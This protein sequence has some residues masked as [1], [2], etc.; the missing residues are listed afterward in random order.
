MKKLLALLFAFTLVAAACGG[1]DDDEASE[2]DTSA[3]TAAEG[4]ADEGDGEAEEEE[5]G[6]GEEAEAPSGEAGS[7]G[8]LLLLQWQAPSQA[9]AMLSSGTKDLLAASLVNEPLAK[10]DPAG[11]IVPTLAAEI[12]TLDNGGV[13]E[14]FTSVTWTLRD[15]ITWSDGTPFTS[16]DVV[17]TWEYCADELTGCSADFTTVDTIVADDE[18][19]V[20]VNFTDPQ[21]YPYVDLVGYLEPV[22]QRAQFEE[23]IG[24]QASA[25]TDQNF[26]PIGTGPYMVTELRPEDTVTYEFNPNY[27]GVA[28]GKPFFGSVTI[29]GGGDAE[30][31]ARSVLEIGEA[32]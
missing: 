17:F 3:D 19:T 32:D 18:F 9:N 22:L 24:E 15:D 20:T 23:C 6:D 16:D 7:G 13:A 21:P 25:C 14:D 10:F 27:R 4:E 11:E 1:G 5:E 28:E 31:A 26:A 8:E 30:A 29:K 12:P 2:D